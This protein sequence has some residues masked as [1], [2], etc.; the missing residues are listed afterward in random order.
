M[1]GLR[2]VV[3]NPVNKHISS[4]TFALEW[5]TFFCNE[6]IEESTFHMLFWQAGCRS[7]WQHSENMSTKSWEKTDRPIRRVDRGGYGWPSPT[8][9]VEKGDSVI[10][11]PWTHHRL[12][13][14]IFSLSRIR[15]I[16]ERKRVTQRI[17]N[18][19]AKCFFLFQ[20]HRMN[21]SRCLHVYD[22]PIVAYHYYLASY[23]VLIIS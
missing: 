15:C 16:V 8:V 13:S 11:Y 12:I 21:F 4:T 20:W 17:Q 1:M 6:E 19:A 22:E 10:I 5:S 7:D 18:F 2:R 14:F 3:Q 23:Q 9:N